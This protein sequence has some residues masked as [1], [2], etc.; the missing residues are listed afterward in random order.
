MTFW[1][2]YSENTRGCP[3]RGYWSVIGPSGNMH[4][5]GV[6]VFYYY[7]Y[8]YTLY[9]SY[10]VWKLMQ[11]AVPLNRFSSTYPTFSED[12]IVLVVYL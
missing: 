7:K 6:Y 12:N 3:N 4:R 2:K 11:N 1:E 5:I 9:E 8:E 10:T